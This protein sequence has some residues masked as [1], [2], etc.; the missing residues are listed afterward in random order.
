MT[1][2]DCL[3]GIRQTT[4][5]G[6][7]DLVARQEV[8]SISGG[9]SS[10][11]GQL[12]TIAGLCNSGEFDPSQGNVPLKDR[13]IIG[14]ATDQSILRFAEGLGPVS[15]LRNFWKKHFEIAF[16]SKNKFMVKVFS[17]AERTGL[18]LALS[19]K[20]IRDWNDGDM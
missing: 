2:T 9:S 19:A 13:K 15:E 10:P 3:I 12:R 16:N 11:I 5:E 1:V 4:P 20:E 18:S 17:L 14:D 6:T 7:R 8:G